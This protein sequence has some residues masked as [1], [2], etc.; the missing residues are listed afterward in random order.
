MATERVVIGGLTLTIDERSYI[1]GTVVW[2]ESGGSKVLLAIGD[3][4]DE[5]VRESIERLEQFTEAL[6]RPTQ[7]DI[8]NEVRKQRM[9]AEIM[10][11]MVDEAMKEK[12]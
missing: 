12:P 8:E 2:L 3:T 10:M 4:R 9:V 7:Q 1:S 11:P 5:A 6:Q